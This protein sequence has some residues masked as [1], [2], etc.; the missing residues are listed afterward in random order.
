M[1]PAAQMKLE[2][3][4]PVEPVGD[5]LQFDDAWMLGEVPDTTQDDATD[6]ERIVAAAGA[7]ESLEW[8]LDR[9]RSALAAAVERAAANG[10]SVDVIASSA[11]ISKGEVAT[12]VWTA[13]TSSA[14][15]E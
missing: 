13:R 15:H 12:M 11:G 14:L 2:S 10:C 6:A 8:E 3:L 9:A 1:A 7:V 5:L 4:A